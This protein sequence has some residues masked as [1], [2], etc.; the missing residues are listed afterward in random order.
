MI[1]TRKI[2]SGILSIVM[3]ASAI[4]LSYASA[5]KV[6][7]DCDTGIEDGYNYELWKDTGNTKWN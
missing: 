6:L 4:P 7:Y 5:G 2:L 1:A 3:V